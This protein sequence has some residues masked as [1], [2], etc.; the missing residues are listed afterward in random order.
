M[1]DF[2]QELFNYLSEEHQVVLLENEMLEIEAIIKKYFKEKN[3]E[4]K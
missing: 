4:E 2:R 3:E 1:E